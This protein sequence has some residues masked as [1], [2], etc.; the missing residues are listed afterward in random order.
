MVLEK[1]LILN[2][3]KKIAKWLIEIPV[4]SYST[5]RH[6]FWARTKRREDFDVII[7]L[8]LIKNNWSMSILAPT[9]N[10]TKAE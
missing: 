3:L 1:N 6:V 10:Y 9:S 7:L 8:V 2:A 4:L 5:T